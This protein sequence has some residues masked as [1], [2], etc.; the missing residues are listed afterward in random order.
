VSDECAVSDEREAKVRRLFPLVRRVA[1]RVAHLVRAAD[2]DDLVGDGAIGLIRAVDTFDPARGT[3]LEVYARR[4]ILGTMLNGLRR[5]DPVSERVRRRMREAERKRYEL[6]QEL[7]ALPAFCELE[8]DDPG[9]RTARVK[10]YRQS[11]LSLDA[12]LPGEPNLLADFG[13][14][15]QA[16]LE[17]RADTAE[18]HDALLRLPARQRHILELHYYGELSLH[19]I[20]KRMSVSPQ[21][22]SQ[23]HLEALARLRRNIPQA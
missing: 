22:V 12:P 8:R 16:Q 10:A 23:L 7:G 2:P 17:R 9:L 18:L 13:V 15:P 11:A 21:R 20:G 1:R 6:A 5:L 4:L 14:D 3:K 19:A